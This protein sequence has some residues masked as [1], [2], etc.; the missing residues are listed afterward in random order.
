MRIFGI[1]P[2]IR[3]WGVAVVAESSLLHLQSLPLRYEVFAYEYLL[4][5]LTQYVKEYRPDIA[6]CEGTFTN[7]TAPAHQQAIGIVRAVMERERVECEFLTPSQVRKA[8][9][10]QGRMSKKEVIAALCEWGY[11][12]TTTHEADAL[13]LCLAYQKMKQSSGSFRA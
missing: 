4:N 3:T 12:L 13:A 8:L 6:V 5:T 2:G 9:F 7:S 1:D 11:A 10:G